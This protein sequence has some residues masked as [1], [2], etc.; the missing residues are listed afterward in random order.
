V[1]QRG[2]FI[3]QLKDFARSLLGRL[4]MDSQNDADHASRSERDKHPAARLHVTL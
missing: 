4:I 3:E 1:R 2:L